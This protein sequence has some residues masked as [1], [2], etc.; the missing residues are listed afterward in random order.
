MS[1]QLV[2]FGNV[3]K[4]E[5]T[6]GIIKVSVAVQAGSKD[7]DK[8]YKTDWYNCTIFPGEVHTQVEKKNLIPGNR[9]MVTGTLIF[10]EYVSSTGE[11]KVQ[12]QVN[13]SNLVKVN[14]TTKADSNG[15]NGS[16]ANAKAAQATP[17]ATV[18]LTTADIPF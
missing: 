1:A 15:S 11:K 14:T 4:V 5:T 18:D 12:Q 6:N 9:V 13:V 3:G 7:A 17:A 16:N 10:N 2:I 8:Q